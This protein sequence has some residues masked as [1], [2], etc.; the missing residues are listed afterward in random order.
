[1]RKSRALNKLLG[2]LIGI[3]IGSYR[4]GSWGKD[5]KEVSDEESLDSHV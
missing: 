3:V 1:M 2:F 5:L 4:N